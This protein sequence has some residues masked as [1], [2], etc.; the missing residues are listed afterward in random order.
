MGVAYS[1]YGGKG[2]AYTVL[3]MKPEGKRPL[4]KPRIDRRIILQWIFRK[5]DGH[6]LDCSGSE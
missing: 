4:R 2:G 6:G 3:V 1:M 5:W